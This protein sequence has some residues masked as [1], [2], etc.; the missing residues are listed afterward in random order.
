[1]PKFLLLLAILCLPTHRASSQPTG[2]AL[3]PLRPVVVRLDSGAVAVRRYV[4]LDTATYRITRQQVAQLVPLRQRVALLDYDRQ[5]LQQQLAGQRR[6][7]RAANA[8]FDAAQASAR[9]LE[10]V[11][12]RPPLLLDARVYGSAGAGILAGL[13][14]SLFHP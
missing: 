10:A 3:A 13:L 6:E 11:P 12:R 4:C 14:Y 7:G 1:M 9:Q 2:R 8:D 5:L